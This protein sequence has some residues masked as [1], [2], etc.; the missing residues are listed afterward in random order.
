MDPIAGFTLPL[1][2]SS[3]SN[4]LPYAPCPI[5]YACQSAIPNPKSN[6]YDFRIPTSEFPSSLCLLP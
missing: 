5:R 1:L 2:L 3:N 4:Y 6:I